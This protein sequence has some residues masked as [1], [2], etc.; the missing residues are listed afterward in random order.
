MKEVNIFL[1]NKNDVKKIN[2]LEKSYDETK[3]F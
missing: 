3:F 1:S 2:L